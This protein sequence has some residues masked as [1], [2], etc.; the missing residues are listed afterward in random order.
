MQMFEIKIAEEASKT[1]D[2]QQKYN[3]TGNV[4]TYDDMVSQLLYTTGITY[5]TACDKTE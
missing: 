1:G 2:L 3:T 4:S 5:Y